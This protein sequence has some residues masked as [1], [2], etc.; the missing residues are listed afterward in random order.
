MDHHCTLHAMPVRARERALTTVAG[1]EI[2]GLCSINSSSL[3][4]VKYHM[5]LKG[6]CSSLCKAVHPCPCSTQTLQMS[7]V[8]MYQLSTWPVWM[9]TLNAGGCHVQSTH[10]KDVEQLDKWIPYFQ[11]NVSKQNC[12]HWLFTLRAHIYWGQQQLLFLSEQTSGEVTQ[13][14]VLYSREDTHTLPVVCL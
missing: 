6:V 8:H 12:F 1:R 4:D 2:T 14:Y 11:R 13:Y 3:L 10:V 9:G 5:K 7:Y